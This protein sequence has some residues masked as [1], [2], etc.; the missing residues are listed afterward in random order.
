[1]FAAYKDKSY[2]REIKVIN[3]L[4]SVTISCQISNLKVS[5]IWSRLGAGLMM[6]LVSILLISSCFS[7]SSIVYLQIIQEDGFN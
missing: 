7:P 2:K 4:V 6:D 5:T 1:M 3:G